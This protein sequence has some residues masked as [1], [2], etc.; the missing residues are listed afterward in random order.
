M[1]KR[2]R[3]ILLGFLALSLCMT[4]FCFP[5]SAR[6]AV[7]SANPYQ[8]YLDKLRSVSGS[9]FPLG[10]PVAFA[11]VCG[12]EIPE[13]LYVTCVTKTGYDGSCDSTTL[14]VL[15]CRSDALTE[16]LSKELI[17]GRSEG[18]GSLLSVWGGKNTVAV[19]ESYASEDV[20]GND[21][22]MFRCSDTR[23]DQSEVFSVFGDPF[24]VSGMP[25]GNQYGVHYLYGDSGKE[26]SETQF[27]AYYAGVE[28][29]GDPVIEIS[30]V[31]YDLRESPFGMGC[32]QAISYLEN[33]IG[34]IEQSVRGF[35]DA[36]LS[37]WFANDVQYVVDKELM[38]G[39]SGYY[40]SPNG[41]TTRGQAVTIL[42]RL[43][44]SPSV[45]GD[46]FSDVKSSDWFYK[47]VQW[48]SENGVAS[49]YGGGRFGPNDT[50]SR[51]QLAAMLYRYAQFKKLDTSSAGGLSGFS[52]SGSV[53]GYA[54]DAM[55]WAVSKGLISGTS[56]GK[57]APA[58]TATRAQLAAILHRFC[59][60]VK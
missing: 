3:S 11:D 48:A 4:V 60:N 5:L 57:L 44:G 1:K 37:D 21:Y 24:H 27:N 49:G 32:A 25:G 33:M 40:F 13:M 20:W 23:F 34:R 22:S 39:I 9:L 45:S 16:V 28:M 53:S 38:K 31:E 36:Q 26:I 19:C 42:Y 18:L 6:A 2:L 15:T 52:D 43:A 59:E 17:F 56:G 58:S 51:E 12:D 7:I 46:G 50:L 8:L 30:L 10:T 54:L 41:T 14:H 55:S 47:A 29:L 35:L